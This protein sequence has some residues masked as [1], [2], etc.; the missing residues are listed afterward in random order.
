M[1]YKL[2]DSTCCQ[3]LKSAA[4]SP[5]DQDDQ[6]KE[7]GVFQHTC[8]KALNDTLTDDD[9]DDDDDDDHHHHHHHH[10]HGTSP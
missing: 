7:P 6:R 8:K 10:H 4:D 9:D 1:R 5:P 2:P 3:E